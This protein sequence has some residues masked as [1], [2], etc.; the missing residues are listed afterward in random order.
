[1]SQKTNGRQCVRGI[2]P[3]NCT[4]WNFSTSPPICN[5]FIEIYSEGINHNYGLMKLNFIKFKVLKLTNPTNVFLSKNHK[6]K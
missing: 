5:V 6:S 4:Y 2:Q 3:C 1:M